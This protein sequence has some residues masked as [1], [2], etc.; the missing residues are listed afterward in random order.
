MKRRAIGVYVDS[1]VFGGIGDEE[2]MD[3]SRA[4]FEQVRSGRFQLKSSLLV[5]NELAKAPDAVRTLF[6]ELLA[7][8][9]LIPVTPD[10]LELQQ[11]C[12]SAGILTAKRSDD[13]LHVAL[14]SVGGAELIVSWNFRHI[15]HFDKVPRYNAVNRL[16]GWRELAIHSPNE[17]ITYADENEDF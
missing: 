4:F 1:S 3:D 10:A 17:V 5:A 13:A 2:F 8:A 6:D 9:E 7:A 11:A 15:V 14:A 12:L 16:Y